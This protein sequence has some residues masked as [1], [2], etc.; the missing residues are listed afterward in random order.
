MAMTSPSSDQ[1]PSLT[2]VVGAIPSVVT[3][4]VTELAA[5]VAIDL[6]ASERY[7]AIRRHF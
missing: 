5:R 7:Q 1:I 3:H 2:E 4:G 6:D